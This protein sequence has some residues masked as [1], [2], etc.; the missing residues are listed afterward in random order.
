MTN[1]E[2]DQL[3]QV[4]ELVYESCLRLNAEDWK[5]YLDLC[6][7]DSFRYRIVNYSPEIRREQCWMDR[8]FKG[9]KALFDL[10]PKHNSDHSPLTRH[11]TVY[12]V[13]FDESAGEASAI[14]LLSI[15]R[16]QLDGVNSHFESG[17]TSL[18][19]VG[20]YEDRIRLGN[21]TGPARLLGRTV[22]LDTRQLDI[23]SHYPF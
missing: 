7:P 17:Q 11:A 3:Q 19:A 10:L 18:F 6:D 20:K 16:T 14:T 4:H 12:K 21:G 13:T 8:D 2:L 9:L 1:R 5:G 23:G 22:R 15:Y